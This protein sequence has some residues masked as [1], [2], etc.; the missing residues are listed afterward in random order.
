MTRAIHF[1]GAHFRC[2][3]HEPTTAPHCYPPQ[4]HTTDVTFHSR[5]LCTTPTT[6]VGA[7]PRVGRPERL[8]D[9]WRESAVVFRRENRDCQKSRPNAPN[10][11]PHIYDDWFGPQGRHSAKRAVGQPARTMKPVETRVF[12]PR[13]VDEDDKVRSD[14][15]S[16]YPPRRFV[17]CFAVS[18]NPNW[19]SRDE[20]H[21]ASASD[22]DIR[23]Q[24]PEA[25]KYV[26][27][28]HERTFTRYFGR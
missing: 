14:V 11:L 26:S 23:C 24:S 28:T 21:D 20:R 10:G 15:S 22:H 16:S 2:S 1:E 3:A 4:N 7:T 13:L 5:T 8:P 25:P 6:R 12:T 9:G 18:E 17:H 19:A 27:H